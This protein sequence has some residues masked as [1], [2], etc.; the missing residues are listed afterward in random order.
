LDEAVEKT[1]HNLPLTVALGSGTLGTKVLRDFASSAAMTGTKAL[2]GGPVAQIVSSL[3]INPA[4]DKV[5]GL[6]SK[7][8]NPNSL[9]SI[10]DQTQ[11]KYGLERDNLGAKI[12]YP[13]ESY[14]NNL[15][16]LYNKIIDDVSVPSTEKKELLGAISKFDQDAISG[17]INANKLIERK[18]QINTL[19]PEMFNKSKSYQKYLKQLKGNLEETRNAI[20]ITHPRWFEASKIVDDITKANNYQFVITE[21]LDQYPQL[22]KYT[23]Q[24]IIQSLIYGGGGT[25]I[26]GAVGGIPGAA[27][28]FFA[29]KGLQKGLEKSQQIYGF[30]KYP[31]AQEVLGKVIKAS[32]DNNIPV[33]TKS[34][35]KLDRLAIEYEKKKPEP[36]KSTRY[37]IV[38]PAT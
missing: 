21:L 13:A 8:I 11:K 35:A 28:G 29:G 16:K 10:A 7:K 19:Y 9:T 18:E 34:L 5:S 27:A 33:F 37:T 6:F 17:K 1:I 32:L 2:G 31:H 30:L 36:S 26:G 38:S 14:R 12:N 23:T 3:A 25:S 4:I 24:P 22:K 20:G 15:D